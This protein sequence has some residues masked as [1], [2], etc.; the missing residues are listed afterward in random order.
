[1]KQYKKAARMKDP[2]KYMLI[3]VK[4]RCKHLGNHIPFSILPE[5]VEYVTHCPILGIELNYFS[6]QSKRGMVVDNA[7]SIDRIVPSLGY[8]PGNVMVVSW[9]ANK[10]KSDITLE[11]MA[12][13]AQHYEQVVLKHNSF[14][15][16]T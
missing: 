5:D 4:A 6:E 7:A 9:R 2:I 12:L 14:Q 11:E 15:L 3:L 10:L 8:I 13:F 1:M 16:S